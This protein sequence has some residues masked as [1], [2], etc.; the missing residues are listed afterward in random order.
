MPELPEIE[1]F[2][3]HVAPL[4]IG[5]RIEGAWASDT[6]ILKNR[7]P[8][9][10]RMLEGSTITEV[11]RRGKALT[12]GHDSGIRT[13]VRFGMT[14]QMYV[15]PPDTPR[16][17]HLHIALSLSDGNELRYIDPRRFGAV[18][19]FEKDEKDTLSG[20]DR[21][22]PEP[23]DPSLTWRYLRDTLSG[24]SIPVKEALMDQTVVAGLGN[25]WSEE[26]LFRARVCPL[27]PCSAITIP[28]WKRIAEEIPRTVEYAIESDAVTD[29]EYLEGKGRNRFDMG[30]LSVYGKAGEP[31][32]VCGCPIVRSVIAG[33]GAHWC[34]RCQRAR[35]TL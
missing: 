28:M 23:D 26:A 15:C 27:D 33:R 16:E 32:P 7:S 13:V 1:T 5:R 6:R 14:G 3:R 24:R 18:W 31:C 22:G 35:A 29:E 21:M 25:I 17:K 19:V 4:T 8:K 20:L 30:C 9:E 34:P 12:F 2:R 10:M 11:G